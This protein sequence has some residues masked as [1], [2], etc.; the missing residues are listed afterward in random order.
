MNSSK[1]CH[2]V[3]GSTEVA[4]FFDLHVHVN[5]LFNPL[6]L[7]ILESRPKFNDRMFVVHVKLKRV[8][9]QLAPLL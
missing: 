9:L 8:Q 5:L 2:Q 6:A 4:I 7:V 3:A 1:S